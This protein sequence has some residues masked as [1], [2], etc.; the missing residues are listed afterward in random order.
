MPIYDYR[1]ASCGFQKE[2]LRKISDAPLTIC[3][4]CGKPSMQKQVSAAGFQ[5]KGKGWYAT[6]FRGGEKSKSEE[7][8]SKPEEPK[9]AEEKKPATTCD[10][11]ASPPCK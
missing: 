6:D 3:P 9:P 8:K 7:P 10:T 5:L 2:V 11:G 4:E 1:C